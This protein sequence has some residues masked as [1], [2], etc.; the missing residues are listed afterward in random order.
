MGGLETPPPSPAAIGAELDLVVR[1]R[2]QIP[3]KASCERSAQATIKL[4]PTCWPARS[5]CR[6]AREL[7]AS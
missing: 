5:N 1:E 7:A 2:G 3:E 4:R 6:L